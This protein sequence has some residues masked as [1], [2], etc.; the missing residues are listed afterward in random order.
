MSTCTN[1][2]EFYQHQTT[3]E[4]GWGSNDMPNSVITRAFFGQTNL[5][6]CDACVERRGNEDIERLIKR[7]L[8][9]P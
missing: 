1:K 5:C 7:G 3:V 4:G 6:H 9:A 2:P 8:V